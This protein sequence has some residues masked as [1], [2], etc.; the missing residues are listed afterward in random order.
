LQVCELNRRW[1]VGGAVSWLAADDL[2][3]YAAKNYI[4]SFSLDKVSGSQGACL[5]CRCG[6]VKI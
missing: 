1:G 2:H 3:G 4:F 5:T 6:Y